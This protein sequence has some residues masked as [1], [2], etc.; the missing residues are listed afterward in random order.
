MLQEKVVTYGPRFLSQ[1][2][3]HKIISVNSTGEK[4][5]SDFYI[6]DFSTSIHVKALQVVKRVYTA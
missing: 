5:T 1:L 3:N 6:A 4:E 2:F